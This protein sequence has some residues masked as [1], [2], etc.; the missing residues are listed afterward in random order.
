MAHHQVT[1]A[2]HPAVA[3]I[4]VVLAAAAILAVAEPEEIG[5]Y[6]E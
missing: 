2:D 6:G 4:G 3:Q 5:R 1:G